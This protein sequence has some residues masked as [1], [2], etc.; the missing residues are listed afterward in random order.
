MD[1]TNA[2]LNVDLHKEVYMSSPPGIAHRPGEFFRLQKALYGLKQ[3]PR[4]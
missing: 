3:V 2:F 4:A 1:V